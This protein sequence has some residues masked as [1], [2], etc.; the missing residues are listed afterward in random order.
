MPQD[1]FFKVDPVE[2]PQQEQTQETEEVQKIKVGEAEY[3]QD[4]LDRLVGL[5][6]TA[7]TYEKQYNTKFDKA[8]SAYGKTTQELKEAKERLAEYE[9]QKELQKSSQQ[10]L[11]PEQIEQAKQQLVQLL[12]GNPITEQNYAK[13]YV[14]MREGEKLLDECTNY[15]TEIN[16]EDGRPKFNKDEIIE[17]MSE[18]GI[19]KPLAA[20]RDK[21]ENEL[22]SWETNQLQNAKGKQM[23]TND[24]ASEAKQPTQP[25]IRT[26]DDLARALSESLYGPQE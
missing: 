17:Y 4:E 23:Y 20:Y 16:G 19:R 24:K 10:Q 22:K 13:F 3:T 7:E 6:K 11:S 21:Y 5:G 12:G 25:K 18:T 2:Q 1:D 26:Q 9:K 14:S 15:E 8:W